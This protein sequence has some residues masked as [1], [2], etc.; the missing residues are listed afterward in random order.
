MLGLEEVRLVSAGG[1]VCQCQQAL[2]GSKG[3]G[4]PRR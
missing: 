4:S 1:P 3:E 2:A